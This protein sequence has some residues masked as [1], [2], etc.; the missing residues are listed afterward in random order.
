[1]ADI[2]FSALPASRAEIRRLQ[3]ARKI[4]AFER[5]KTLPWYRGKLDQVRAAHLDEPEEW[6]KIPLLTKDELRQF[7]HAP[8]L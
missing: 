5:A 3:S 6:A 2:D 7:D 1:M 8:T 4:V